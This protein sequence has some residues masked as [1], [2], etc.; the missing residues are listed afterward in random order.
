MVI[1]YV[2]SA[3][4][5]CLNLNIGKI[6]LNYPKKTVL[7]KHKCYEIFINSREIYLHPNNET[8]GDV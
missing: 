5:A 3:Q 2:Q 4:L 7:F 6:N 1:M 8:P